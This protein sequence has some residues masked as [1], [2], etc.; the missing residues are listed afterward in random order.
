VLSGILSGSKS[1]GAETLTVA[2]AQPDDEGDPKEQTTRYTR[3]PSW[4]DEI[5]EFANAV[6]RDVPIVSGSSDDAL[7]TMDL[8]YRIYCADPAW[9]ERWG[10]STAAAGLTGRN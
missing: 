10:L 2:W 8:V 3:D 6:L 1:Y 7:R 5:D 9:R 4:E